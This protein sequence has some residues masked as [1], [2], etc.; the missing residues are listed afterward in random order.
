MWDSESEI[1][2]EGTLLE[3][4]MN[5]RDADTSSSEESRRKKRKRSSSEA[6]IPSFFSFRNLCSRSQ[7]RKESQARSMERR[8]SRGGRRR[9]RKAII[10]RR[11]TS[12]RKSAWPKRRRRK[13][14]RKR[15]KQRVKR[16]RSR[17]R[18]MRR[19]WQKP[20]R[21]GRPYLFRA[22]CKVA[23]ALT[24]KIGDVRNREERASK[25]FLA[26]PRT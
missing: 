3:S 4:G 19:K 1:S 25:L 2:K 6:W 14:I 23:T 8:Q 12:R 15:R 13:R 18:C 21:W 16:I 22:A 9:A 20:E 11:L 24:N 26:F 7:S 17:K 10:A 5:A